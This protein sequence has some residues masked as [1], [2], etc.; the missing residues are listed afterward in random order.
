MLI[1]SS[2]VF[3]S[4]AG[5][6][7][8]SPATS[9]DGVRVF[10]VAD[11]PLEPALPVAWKSASPSTGNDCTALPKTAPDGRIWVA[12][13]EDSQ[14]WVF[15]PDG[16]FVETWG[17]VGPDEG[18]LDMDWNGSGEY[19]GGIAFGP[20]GSMWTI[21]AGNLRLQHFGADGTLLAATGGFG[22]ADGSFAK[23]ATIGT[24]ADGNVYVGDGARRD[25]QVFAPD[26]TFQRAIAQGCC[27]GFAYLSVTPE[28]H[29]YVAAALDTMEEYARDGT[30]LATIHL[31]GDPAGSTIAPDGT[32]YVTLFD[33]QGEPRSLIAFD[34]TDGTVLHH[35]P[36]TFEAIALAQDGSA[37]YAGRWDWPQ[38]IA[39]TLP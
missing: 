9:V 10:D 8:E 38:L 23:P 3:A 16:S 15:D 37:Y 19:I 20:D 7:A 21:D 11:T 35:W 22:A 30:H 29:V 1:M 17:T 34:P 6:A 28:G 31:P 5:A 14:F 12:A 27:D 39:Y 4:S 26:G 25:V 13:C 24:D 36:A 18:Q 32:L 2:V 33:L